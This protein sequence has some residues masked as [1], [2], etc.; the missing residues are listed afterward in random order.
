LTDLPAPS[1]PGKRRLRFAPSPTGQLHIGS[2]RTA[3]F[4]YCLAGSEGRFLVR[5]EDTDRERY[6][7]GA[8]A[9]YLETLAWMGLNWDEGPDIGGPCAPYI[10]SERLPHYHLAAERLLAAGAAYRCFCSKDRLDQLR[11]AQRAAGQ[12]TRYDRRCW[13]LA[14]AE[15]A[16]ELDRGTSHV[17]RL[18]MPDGQTRWTDLVLGPQEFQNDEIDDQVLLKSDGF[19]TYHLAHVV[20]DHLMGITHVIRGVEWVPSTPKHLA[21]YAALDWPPPAFA[22]V[23]LVLGPDHKRLAKRHG[24]VAVA[25]YRDMGYLPEALVNLIAFL[26]WSPGTEEEIFSLEELRSRMSFDRLQASPAIFDQQR[27]DHLN[28][29]WIRRISVTDLAQRLRR[30]LPEASE[31]QLEPIAAMVQERIHRLDEVPELVRFAFRQPSPSREELVG[32]LDPSSATEFLDQAAELVGDSGSELMGGLKEA[33]A[34]TA[35][36]GAEKRH[37]RDCMQVVRVAITGQRVSPP[38]PESIDLIGKDE[39]LRRIR[40]AQEVIGQPS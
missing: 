9:D 36:P 6:V 28:G 4:S 32:R 29:V 8:T 3:L 18:L 25:D 11:E 13:R 24:S 14:P 16:A 5:I 15:V 22:H 21:V 10:E 2:V 39:A 37:V 23:P 26:G 7:P 34:A 27:L 31:A 35:A 30:F 1:L 33:A 12:P 40:L 20:D 17:V 38:L 19:P